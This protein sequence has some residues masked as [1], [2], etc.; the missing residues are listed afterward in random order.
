MRFLRW[1]GKN[2]TSLILSLLL[3]IVIWT[4]A[5]TS[6]NPNIEEEFNVPLEVIQQATDIAIVDPLP[7]TVTLKILAPESIIQQLEE[8][9]PIIA[10][11]DLTDI[12]A[13]NYLFTVQVRIPDQLKPIRILEQSRK[14]L[15]LKI[16]NLISKT[17]PTSILEIGRASCR[18]RV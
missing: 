11:I 17:F 15:E 8:D 5:V 9:N 16:S 3:A 12:V 14:Q 1:L 7:E 4:S 10:F 2:L 13:G 18:E 6:T